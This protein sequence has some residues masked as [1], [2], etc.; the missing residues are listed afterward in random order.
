MI[1]SSRLGDDGNDDAGDADDDG[2]DG[3]TSNTLEL[4]GAL[5]MTGSAVPAKGV[6]WP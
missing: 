4:R 2:I 6:A 1:R 3:R 5:L